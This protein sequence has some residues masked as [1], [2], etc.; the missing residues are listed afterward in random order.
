MELWD[1]VYG[2]TGR[3]FL[4]LNFMVGWKPT[5]TYRGFGRVWHTDNKRFSSLHFQDPTEA[6][7][8]VLEHSPFNL[9]RIRRV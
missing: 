9:N 4:P 1:A 2:Q 8:S 6:G 3:F 5:R 7:I